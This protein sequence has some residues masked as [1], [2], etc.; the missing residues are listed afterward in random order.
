MVEL[1]M[2]A[3]PNLET[4]QRM[5]D[6]D[7][8]VPLAILGE[9]P[10]RRYECGAI[11]FVAPGEALGEIAWS[12]F[13]VFLS[14]NA[15]T[16][17]MQG[18]VSIWGCAIVKDER[19]T[20][21]AEDVIVTGYYGGESLEAYTPHSF[22]PANLQANT[23]SVFFLLVPYGSLRGP[24]AVSKTHDIRGRFRDDIIENR[25]TE[26]AYRLVTGKPH[27]PT[28]LYYNHIYSWNG[29]RTLSIDELDYFRVDGRADN[30]VTHQTMQWLWS[31]KTGDHSNAI[32][33]TGYFGQ[34]IYEGHGDLRTM[35]AAIHYKDAGYNFPPM[36]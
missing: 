21:L 19:R 23:A 32:L 26:P 5:Y 31:P 11:I 17:Q 3:E 27:Y 35:N 2:L 36:D 34:N 12:N 20:Y 25:L 16:Q 33:N 7:V 9:R 6:A 14:T 18:N 15:M 4:F 29:L 10:L 8:R 1:T 28:A 22:D 30:T 24:H 13:N